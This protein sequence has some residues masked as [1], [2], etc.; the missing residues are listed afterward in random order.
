MGAGIGRSVV[1]DHIDPAMVADDL[2][3][4][5]IDLTF[6]A[7]VT[8]DPLDAKSFF[9]RQ[10]YGSRERPRRWRCSH[11]ALRGDHRRACPGEGENIGPTDSMGRPG[12]DGDLA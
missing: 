11:A 7:H 2:L 12:N 4:E 8:D 9:G 3:R 5:T 1:D 6:V 10:L